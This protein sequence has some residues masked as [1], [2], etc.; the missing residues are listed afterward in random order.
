[1]NSNYNIINVYKK[2][3][4]NSELVTQILYGEKFKVLK[5]K[6][7]WLKVKL[8][9]DNYIGYILKKN[10]SKKL[11]PTHKICVL[12]AKIFKKPIRE[13][14]YSYLPFASKIEVT[15]KQGNFLK[16]EKNKW[17]FKKNVKSIKFKY[18]NIFSKINIFKGIKYKWGGKDFNGVDCSALVQLFFNFN[19]KFCPRDT[20][21]QLNY[22]KKKI[23]LQNIKK[24]DLFF[25]K[26]H[27][28][29]AISKK[30]LIHA[31]GPFKKVIT[32]NIDK[33][34]K[35]IKDTANLKLISI[36]RI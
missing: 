10:Y 18:N 36:K 22:F 12:K 9:N 14:H 30:N 3:F 21:D 27:V 6:D 8:I 23:K 20:K 11:Y 26:G 7:K 15:G 19:N 33:T 2:K 35:R 4:L 1:M 13:K 32:M 5:I 34:I 29:I 17:V 31:Y 16:F 25:W 28:A 24:N